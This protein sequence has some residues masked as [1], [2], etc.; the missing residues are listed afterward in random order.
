[1]IHFNSLLASVNS[2]SKYISVTLT[3]E[4]PEE[5]HILQ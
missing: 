5:E 4:A 3:A 1:M 2:G